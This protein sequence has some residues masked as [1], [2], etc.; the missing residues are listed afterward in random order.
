MYKCTEEDSEG[1]SEFEEEDDD[2][3]INYAG[4]H[5]SE[6]DQATE[7]ED[8]EEEDNIHMAAIDNEDKD[9]RG[10][11]EAEHSEEEQVNMAREVFM[12]VDPFE[13]HA[14][15]DN[16]HG[17]EEGDEMTNKKLLNHN[18]DHDTLGDKTRLVCSRLQV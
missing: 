5:E 4:E 13:D 3:D 6:W 14:G 12:E 11:W 10:S 1:P 15:D 2:E 9:C 18:T 7:L 8:S 16:V 17:D